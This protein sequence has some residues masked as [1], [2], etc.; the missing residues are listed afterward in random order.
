MWLG[1][2]VARRHRRTVKRPSAIDASRSSDPANTKPK[3]GAPAALPPPVFGA[4]RGGVPFWDAELLRCGLGVVPAE[5]VRVDLGVAVPVDP[6]TAD[7]RLVEVPVE[8][9]LV[10]VPVDPRPV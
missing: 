1:H 2:Q 5:A 10:E 9:R 7:P 4:A 6:G 8:P 3:S